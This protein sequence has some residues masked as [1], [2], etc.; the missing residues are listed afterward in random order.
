MVRA[1]AAGLLVWL[2]LSAAT[3]SANI[4]FYLAPDG[5]DAWSGRLERPNAARTDGPLATLTGARDAV[6]K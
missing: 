2:A 4:T 6:R 5:N 3:A 1:I